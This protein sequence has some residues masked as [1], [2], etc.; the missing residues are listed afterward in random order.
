VVARER[1]TCVFQFVYLFRIIEFCIQLVRPQRTLDL[2]KLTARP[3][4]LSLSFSSIL[5]PYTWGRLLHVLGHYQLDITGA[6]I[7]VR[8]QPYTS[9][10]DNATLVAGFSSFECIDLLKCAKSLLLKFHVETTFSFAPNSDSGSP[11][12]GECEF[13][14]SPREVAEVGDMFPTGPTPPI[15]V[16]K[17]LVTPSA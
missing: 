2:F 5:V 12:C 7:E 4:S 17:I 10:G 16:N 13:L 9:D 3:S 14:Q 15:P 1:L 8:Y 6:N 11:T